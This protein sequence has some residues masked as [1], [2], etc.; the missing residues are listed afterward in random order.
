MKKTLT[1]CLAILLL[2]TLALPAFAAPSGT[3]QWKN[4]YT[5]AGG[6]RINLQSI[7]G[8][9]Y[10]FLP[11]DVSP[12]AVA[13]TFELS[14]NPA[15]FSV[16]GARKSVAAAN[17]ETFD[18][19]ALCGEGT[20]Y[21]LS[22]IA[23]NSAD[24]AELTFTVVPTSAV[25]NMY[26]VSDNPATQGRDWV[27]ASPDKSNKA[28]GS[29][30]MTD[31]TGGRVYD[32]KLTQIKGR[33]NSTWQ[34]D[35]R[36]YQIKLAEKT[37]LLQTGKK[38]NRAKT[39]VLL[40]NAA[41]QS[42]IRNSIVYDLSVAMGM[43]PGIECRP[44][45]LYYDGEYRG[46]YLLCEKVEINS[47]RVDVADLEEETENAN[48]DVDF[49]ACEVKTG[50]TA[51]GASYLYCEGLVSPEN[52]TGG[53]LLEM[54]TAARASAEK[55][56]FTTKRGQCV[57]VKSP[58]FCSKEQMDYISSYYQEFEDT[59]YNEGTHPTT[60]KPLSTYANIRSLAECYIINE[61]T[62]N[63]DGYRTSAYFYKDADN[64]IL[65]AG[66][67]WDY[68]LSFGYGWG[69]FVESCANPE[70]F[71]TLRSNLG[72]ALYD[73]GE[74]RQAVNDVYTDTVAPLLTKQLLAESGK[75][76]PAFTAYRQGIEAT[77]HANGI[78]W[79]I[80]D[81]ARNANLDALLSY[82]TVRNSWLTKELATWNAET[83]TPLTGFIDVHEKDWFFDV[84]TAASDYA[85]MNGM[86]NGIFL[87]SGT[88]TRAQAAKVLFEMAGGK[89]IPFQEVFP[90]VKSTDWF[91]NA[92]IWASQQEIVLGFDDG[93]FYPESNITRQ[94]MVVLLYR[95]L[96]SPKV[97]GRKL[98]SFGDGSTVADY[99]RDAM[100]WAVE[101]G[102]VDGY[103]DATVRPY[104]SIT[105]AELAA[106]TVRFYEGFLLESDPA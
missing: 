4:V 29:L 22:V 57:V 36:P 25:A 51:N 63:P 84:V 105:R 40:A 80:S 47:G 35:K 88:T 81:A 106:L 5:V 101:E 13:L 42:L 33:G 19:T 58:E 55:C 75:D 62:K 17:G 74:F 70:D 61:L 28:T 96:G 69:E 97:S 104:N 21:T 78:L 91:A 68:D 12:K 38:E 87:P 103:E 2:L 59:V 73:S 46:A 45:N 77:A 53:Y 26:L 9:N 85:L 89:A 54:D 43:T 23:K 48:P 93:K 76:L 1:F 67:I 14:G 30:F 27:E 72:T 66:P 65:Q 102:V 10:L 94:D 6:S 15:I 90:D 34:L 64:D 20:E 99:A 98:A 52:V 95:S 24:S 82:I 60:G 86:G 56:Y 92:V 3:M 83:K 41:D 7:G 32:G 11:G 8:K 37:D 100:E 49:D 44:V 31:K 79:N 18:L 50:K 71:F 16:G 39:W